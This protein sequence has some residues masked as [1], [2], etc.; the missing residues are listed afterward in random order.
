MIWKCF[1]LFVNT[2]SAVD[3]CSVLNRDNLVQPIHMQ[4]SQ[5]L[6]TFSW[7]FSAF[8]KS[9][10]NFEYFQ[11]KKVLRSL[12]I[13]FQGYGL[14]KSWLDICV[15][16]PASDYPSKSNMANGSQL[17]LNLSDNACTIFIDQREGS[18]VEKSLF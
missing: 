18:L 5:K 3:K 15:K 4:L 9:K 14:R 12:V 13:Y 17:C 1:R 6:K 16:G 7:F 8:P 10:L 11:K 2:M